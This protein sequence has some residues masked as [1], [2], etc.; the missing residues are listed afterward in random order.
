MHF[1]EDNSAFTNCSNCKTPIICCI[2]S[3]SQ[4]LFSM[5]V[6]VHERILVMHEHQ[7][8]MNEMILTEKVVTGAFAAQGKKLQP[9]LSL[10]G[11]VLR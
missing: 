9:V 3:V 5:I 7:W 2:T 4:G 8:W 11:L 6:H 10:V 1:K